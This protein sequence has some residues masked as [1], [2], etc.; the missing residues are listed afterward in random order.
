MNENPAVSDLRAAAYVISLNR[1]K[2]LYEAM[3]I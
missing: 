2:G 3:G 1:I